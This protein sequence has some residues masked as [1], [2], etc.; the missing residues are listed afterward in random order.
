[1]AYTAALVLFMI[2]F[3]VFVLAR[4]LASDWLGNQIPRRPEHADDQ[5]DDLPRRRQEGDQRDIDT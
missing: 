1:M 2:V 5:V 4:L 3:I